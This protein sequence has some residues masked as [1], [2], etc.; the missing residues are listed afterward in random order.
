MLVS[1]RSAVFKT[2][3][4]DGDVSARA[5]AESFVLRPYVRGTDTVALRVRLTLSEGARE[6]RYAF[7]LAFDAQPA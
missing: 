2:A 5:T 3:A 4:V 1:V 7:P 6:G